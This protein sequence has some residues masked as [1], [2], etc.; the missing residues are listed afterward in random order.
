MRKHKKEKKKAPVLYMQKN[1]DAFS[2]IRNLVSAKLEKTGIRNRAKKK[3]M[4]S[5]FILFMGLG[6]RHNFLNMARYG[7]Y[8]EKTYRNNFEGPFDFLSFNKEIVLDSCSDEVIIAFDP[9]YIPKSGKETP[10]IGKYW[11]GVSGKALRGLEIGGIGAV[12]VVNNTAL[13]LE[14]VQTL[15]AQELQKRGESLVTYYASIII[16][17]KD[18]LEG[19]S[20]YLVADGYFAKEKFVNPINAQTQ[21]ELISKMRKDANLYY[22]YQGKPTGKKGRPKVKDGKIDMKNI[23]KERFKMAYEDEGVKVY[24][25]VVYSVNLKRKIKLAYIEFWEDGKN[26]NRYAVL[27]STDLKLS[28]ERI[29]RYYKARFQIE[30]LFRDAKQFAGLTHSQARSKNKLHFH[31]NTSLTSV[32]I[33]KAACYLPLE[34]HQKNGFSMS[35]VRTLY[36]NKIIAD[37]IFSNLGLDLSC[38]KINQIYW[39]ALWLGKIAS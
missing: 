8:T 4:T 38:E 39:D 1:Q 12:D 30:F 29:Y 9:S 10:G 7:N 22:L 32:S 25:G 13:S 36:S 26:T 17:R 34:S 3:F 33:A 20:N 21:L 23:D 24:E 16:G 15:P 19:L 2:K 27:F 35:N 6:G 37:R 11:S 14:A 31:F 28:G 18:I 5:L